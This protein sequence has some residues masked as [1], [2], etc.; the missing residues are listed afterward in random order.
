MNENIK[1]KAEVLHPREILVAAATHVITAVCAFLAARAPVM[2]LFAPFGI[3]FAA[4][5]PTPYILTAGL[6][7]AAGYFIPIFE[8]SGFRYFAALF[9]V[10]T[11]R[12]L[13]GKIEG[14]E[15]KSWVFALISFASSLVT[16]LATIAGGSFSFSYAIIEAVLTASGC[17]FIHRCI[18][19]YSR[20]PS[21]LNSEE[22]ACTVITINI[23]LMGLY[24]LTVFGISIG[25]IL[26]TVLIMAVARYSK[27]Q[28]GAIA[29][30]TT[31]FFI[32][33][34]GGDTASAAIIFA[35][36]GLLCGVFGALSKIA[37]AASFVVWCLIGALF[38]NKDG[39]VFLLLS[40]SAFGAAIFLLLPKT[41]CVRFGKLFSA[42][43]N[44]PSLEGLRRALTMRLFFASKALSD[45]S[46]TVKDV[47]N[48]L[49]LINAPDFDW[50]S[51]SVKDDACRGC[52]LCGYCWA[53]K[54]KATNDALIYMTKLIKGGD[55][56]PHNN[57]PQEWRDRCL[58]P[59]RVGSA[60]VRY[61]DEYASRIAAEMRIEEIRGVVSD[62]FDG[63]SDMLYDLANEFEHCEEF[64]SV[65][66]ARFSG[67]L[68]DIDIRASDCACRIDK[69]GRLSIEARVCIPNNATVNRMDILRVAEAVCERD[70]EAPTLTR[71]KSEMFIQITEKANLSVELGIAQHICKDGAVCGDAYTT[72]NDGKGRTILILSDGMGTGGRAAVDGAMASGLME[73]LLK[74]GFGYDCALR[75]V[76]SSMLFKSTDESLAT[77]DIACIDLFSGKTELLK[78]GAAPTV[79]RRNGRTGRASGTSLPVGILKD[80]GFDKASV[81]L[82]AGDIL[83][84]LSDGA[85]SSGTDWICAELESYKNGSA[86]QL[87]EKIMNIAIKRR[88]DGH[89][90]DI[91]V[92][93]AII[94]KAV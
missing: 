81:S 20:E 62:Q 10:C 42:P 84:M 16:S 26:A 25:R 77:V 23:L 60:I 91:T 75:I 27:S 24:P 7:A 11:I 63:I 88:S 3:A 48:E 94:E 32:M 86:Q 1:T 17:F 53:R 22:L 56:E 66:A 47:S 64:D 82:K 57:A 50:V 70:F 76:N 14:F 28:G 68:K 8:G 83:L 4:G 85:T 39:A 87:A 45:V 43:V 73:R 30:C 72:F 37:C 89:D 31:A 51:K 80:I 92:M 79:I 54:K 93:A 38:E 52:S 55:R 41:V 36:G 21:G 12:L 40:E 5:M 44:I 13:L 58:R 59:M 69:Y 19:A 2:D 49:S 9:A 90:D 6:G 74:A 65:L 34:C 33:L 61:Y 71:T 78:V 67:A 46:E 15:R 29:G 18:Y 35:V